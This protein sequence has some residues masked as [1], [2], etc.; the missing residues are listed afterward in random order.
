[1]EGRIPGVAGKHYCLA[2]GGYGL[3]ENHRALV[4]ADWR[5]SASGEH[6]NLKKTKAGGEGII[7]RKVRQ[8]ERRVPIGNSISRLK[9]G[10]RIWIKH[11]LCVGG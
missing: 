4:S 5:A 2:G 6:R 7:C 9:K 11:L 3:V 10:H 8:Q 1:M